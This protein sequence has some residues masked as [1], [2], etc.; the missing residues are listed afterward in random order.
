MEKCVE[1]T[2]HWN[3]KPPTM[4]KT[5]MLHAVT[6]TVME[7]RESHYHFHQ[8]ACRN[9]GAVVVAD[10]LCCSILLDSHYFLNVS[11]R[12]PTKCASFA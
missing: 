11:M 10:V 8:T 9:A 3:L 4:K 1:H 7:F 2:F 12:F 6:V 5:R